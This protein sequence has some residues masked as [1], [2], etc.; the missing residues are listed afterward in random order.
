MQRVCHCGGRRPFSP[1]QLRVSLEPELQSP[2][3]PLPPPVLAALSR[4]Q[5]NGEAGPGVLHRLE[6]PGEYKPAGTIQHFLPTKKIDCILASALNALLSEEAEIM[7]TVTLK[8][9]RFPL[10]TCLLFQ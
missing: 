2:L 3:A 1:A 10:R 8:E 4:Q 6:P 9:S 7:H 5:Q